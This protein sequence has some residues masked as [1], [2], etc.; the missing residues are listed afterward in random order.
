MLMNDWVVCLYFLSWSASFSFCLERREFKKRAR[1]PGNLS[2]WVGLNLPGQVGV[3]LEHVHCTPPQPQRLVKWV[4]HQN[5]CTAH[6]PNPTDW[7]SGCPTGTHALHTTQTPQPGQVDVPL[8]HTA[9]HPNPTDWSSGCPTGTHV[10]HTTQTPQT[11]QV[12]V[13]NTTDW[14]SGC[15]KHHRLVKW[16]SQTRKTGEAGRH[17]CHE[18]WWLLCGVT[19]AGRHGCHELWWL[20]ERGVVWHHLAG[21]DV[22]NP[23]D[24]CVV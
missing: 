22:M 19:S 10:L 21:M 2:M 17:E 4:S 6:H 7:S 24:C 9:H 14:S 12:G 15:P 3:P 20:I 16:V 5:T 1:Q 23:E 8:E 18:C 11:G 13:P